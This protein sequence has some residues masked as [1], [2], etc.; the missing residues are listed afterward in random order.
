MCCQERIGF[1]LKFKF[2]LEVGI[3]ADGVLKKTIAGTITVP[4]LTTDELGDKSPPF[5]SSCDQT[6]WAKVFGCVATRCWPEL[7]DTFRQLVQQAKDHWRE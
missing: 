7:Q 2:K 4:E 6:S 1:E 3:L 5:S